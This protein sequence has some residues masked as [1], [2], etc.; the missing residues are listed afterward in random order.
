M[1][2]ALGKIITVKEKRLSQISL[3]DI[4]NKPDSGEDENRQE[5]W[6]LNEAEFAQHY[7]GTL[8]EFLNEDDSFVNL[9]ALESIMK[10][11]DAKYIEPNMI[12][13]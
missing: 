9:K 2:E 5:S 13:D 1:A 11:I 6:E 4:G 7:L 10:L 3:R 8:I 12:Q